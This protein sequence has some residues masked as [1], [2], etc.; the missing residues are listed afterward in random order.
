M[1]EITLT[2]A[3]AGRLPVSCIAGEG[4]PGLWMVEEMVKVSGEGKYNDEGR[5]MDSGIPSFDFAQDK[6]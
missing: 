1:E 6:L 4:R 5:S 2:P 3:T